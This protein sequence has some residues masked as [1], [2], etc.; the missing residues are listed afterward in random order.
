MSAEQSPARAGGSAL[1]AL[2]DERFVSL[3]TF[4]K[5]GVP[6]STPVWIARDRDE[7]LV[8]TPADS[9]KVKRLRNSHR[10]ELRPCSRRGTVDADAP[11]IGAVARIQDARPDVLRGARWFAEKYGLEY[12]ITLL[13]ERIVARQ[14]RQR[15]IL[16][17]TAG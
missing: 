8:T 6:V 10:V 15:V 17:I 9:G 2:G 4:R 3:T 12:R 1:L 13:I 16:R 7:L 11:A 5:S 14:Q